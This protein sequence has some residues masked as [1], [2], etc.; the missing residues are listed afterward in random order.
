MLASS[1][2]STRARLKYRI[3]P[4]EASDEYPKW[5]MVDDA[6]QGGKVASV[7]DRP[8]SIRRGQISPPPNRPGTRSPRRAR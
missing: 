3:I 7:A 4:A 1:H 5:T 6:S 2:P 8:V